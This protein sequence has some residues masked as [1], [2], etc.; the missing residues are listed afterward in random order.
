MMF[1]SLR[2][3]ARQTKRS[4]IRPRTIHATSV[5]LVD[6]KIGFFKG[7][8]DKLSNKVEEKKTQTDEEQFQKTINFMIESKSLTMDDFYNHLNSGLE[9]LE[10]SWKGSVAKRVQGD[11]IEQARQQVNIFAAMTKAE[12]LKPH[13]IKRKEKIRIAHEAGVTVEV[14]NSSIKQFNES[15]MFHSWVQ[16]RHR[17]GLPMPKN[18]TQSQKMF[19]QDKQGISSK[20]VN[21]MMKMN[22]RQH[23]R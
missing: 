15:S 8:T 21:R 4:F 19:Q 5:Q 20:K 9:E 13:I 22:K 6:E 2:A 17:L 18:A 3:A 12:R 14:V 7:L 1:T 23:P 10:Q 16:R 11:E